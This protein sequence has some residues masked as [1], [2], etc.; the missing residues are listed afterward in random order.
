MAQKF[1][2]NPDFALYWTDLAYENFAVDSAGKVLVIDAEHI[3]VVDREATKIG[4]YI[5][6]TVTNNFFLKKVSK[7]DHEMPQS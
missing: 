6:H 4:G 2:D 3:I 7:Y 1:T 5:Q